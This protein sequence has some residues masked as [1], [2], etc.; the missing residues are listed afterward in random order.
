[1]LFAALYLDTVCIYR[2]LRPPV[3]LGGDAVAQ[4]AGPPSAQAEPIFTQ[5][6]P[7]VY[8]YPSPLCLLLFMLVVWWG[9]V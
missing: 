5:D 2:T 6:V 3:V 7:Y 1:M 9:H 8:V 4:A